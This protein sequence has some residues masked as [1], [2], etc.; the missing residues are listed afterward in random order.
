MKK[1][2]SEDFVV[3]LFMIKIW[4][5]YL[6]YFIFV[7]LVLYVIFRIWRTKPEIKDYGILTKIFVKYRYLKNKLQN[8]APTK[9][10]FQN[11]Q[12]GLLE[13]FLRRIKVEALKIEIW[14]SKKLEG[15]KK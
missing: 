14:A 4:L 13:K 7:F 10:S 12:K 15:I 6:G 2:K 9:S 5:L 8:K 3:Y 11:L 1:L